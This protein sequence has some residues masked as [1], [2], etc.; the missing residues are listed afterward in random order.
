MVIDLLFS[1]L[2]GHL[3]ELFQVCEMSEGRE[4]AVEFFLKNSRIGLLQRTGINLFHSRIDINI[5]FDPVARLSMLWEA[6]SCKFFL[7]KAS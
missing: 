2:L 7:T 6:C 1:Q 3:I 5:A 4:G